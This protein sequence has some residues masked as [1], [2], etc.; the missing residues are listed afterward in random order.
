MASDQ[1]KTTSREERTIDVGITRV[2][3]PTEPSLRAKEWVGALRSL[4]V[5]EIFDP[6]LIEAIR[7]D[8]RQEV[9]LKVEQALVK[10]L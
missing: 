3:V 1:P 8:A 5:Y 6:N 2:V 9:L 7:R 10:E 4:P